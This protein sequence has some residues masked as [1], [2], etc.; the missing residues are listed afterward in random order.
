MVAV[1][2]LYPNGSDVT[3]GVVVVAVV[4][5]FWKWLCGAV[6]PLTDKASTAKQEIANSFITLM[7][8]FKYY[9]WKLN[10]NKLNKIS[11]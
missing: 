4:V 11:I 5:V 10:S 2:V 1:G 9:I 7:F 3:T 8:V 6:K